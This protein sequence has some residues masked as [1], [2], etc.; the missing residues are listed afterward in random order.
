MLGSMCST[1]KI[2]GKAVNSGGGCSSHSIIFE[3]KARVTDFL[4]LRGG[5][6]FPK[7]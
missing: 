6:L 7:V 3:G 1:E 4:Q 5:V 2:M